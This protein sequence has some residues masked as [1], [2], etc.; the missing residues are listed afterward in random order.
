MEKR[1]TRDTANLSR[2]RRS[3]KQ[4]RRF[5]GC[6]AGVSRRDLLVTFS[7]PSRDLLMALSWQHV[8]RRDRMKCDI[9]LVGCSVILL[10]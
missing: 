9:V 5:R 8:A 4:E 1:I 10:Q 6:D 7:W 3:S 2:F